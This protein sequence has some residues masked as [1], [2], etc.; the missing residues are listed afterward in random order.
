MQPVKILFLAANPT[1]TGRSAFDKEAREI[2]AKLRAAEYRHIEFV[3]KWAVRSSDL[4]HYFNQHPAHVVHFS[5][6]GSPSQEIIL[7]NN[8]GHTKPVSKTALANLFRVFNRKGNIRVV[9]LNACYSRAQAQAI[10]QH[11]DCAIGMNNAIGDEAAR[12]FAASF[13]SALGFGCSIQDAFDQGLLALQLE[14]IPEDLTPELLVREGVDPSQLI[15]VTLDEPKPQAP[16]IQRYLRELKAAIQYRIQLNEQI[17]LSLRDS[18][19]AVNTTPQFAALIMAPPLGTKKQNSSIPPETTETFSNF[20]EA[21]DRLENRV[22][23]LGAPGAG[24]TTTLLQFAAS[25]I[26]ARL[27]NPSS[28]IPLWFSLH[29]WNFR[30]PLLRWLQSQYPALFS[31]MGSDSLP[32]LYIFDGLDELGEKIPD[33]PDIPEKLRGINPRRHVLETLAEQLEEAQIVL[34]CREHDYE[35]IAEKVRLQGAVTLLPLSNAQIESYL[36]DRNQ[37]ALWNNLIKDETLLELARTPLLL[38]LLKISVTDT[39]YETQVGIKDSPWTASRIFNL[40]IQK[41][42]EHQTQKQ[43]LPFSEETTRQYLSE[44]AASMWRIPWS[45]RVSLNFYEANRVVD[46]QEDDFISFAQDMHFLRQSSSGQIEFIH[47]KFRDYCAIPAVE[48][49]L[50]DKD[51]R[52]R[53]S[54]ARSLGYIGDASAIPALEKAL[55]DKDWRVRKDAVR[56]LG[57]INDSSARPALEKALRDKDWRVREDAAQSLGHIGDASAIPALEKALGCIDSN[58]RK[59][60]ANALSKL[61]P[62]A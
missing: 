17:Y 7:E 43:V 3:S 19:A 33:D 21:F 61:R 59:A 31:T 28:P 55:K 40:Y 30:Q 38:T 54:A 42:F 35:Q 41:R 39:N 9:I 46:E 5:G 15:L 25:A 56:A 1:G 2:E 48:K 49:T 24:K 45:P 16:K 13:Y 4:L 47:L 62:R 27:N 22:L 32:L 50:K 34:S 52:V 20:A 36:Q 18:P 58:V 12:I 26:D 60:V 53:Y 57:H 44:I 6:Q 23:L 51:W 37:T 10:T 11:A 8:D 14:G 29:Q